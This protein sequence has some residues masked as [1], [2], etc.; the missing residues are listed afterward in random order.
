MCAEGGYHEIDNP[1]AI[2][3]L[4]NLDRHRAMEMRSFAVQLGRFDLYRMDDPEVLKLIREAIRDSRV[5]AVQK[6]AENSASPSA[7][8][9]LRRLLAQVEKQT[10]ASCPTEAASTS[11]S[12]T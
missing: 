6:G 2:W 12:S 3:M 1:K 7:T 11:W 10:V 9:Q 4:E 8:V 5:I